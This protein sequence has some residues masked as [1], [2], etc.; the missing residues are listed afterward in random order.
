MLREIK[1]AL[2]LLLIFF[3]FFF[4]SKYYFSEKNIKRNNK[5]ILQYQEKVNTKFDNLPSFKSDTDNIIE[6]T[7]EIKEFNNK[8]ERNF[9]NLLKPNEK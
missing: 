5:I 4:V 2:Y 6:Y 1:Y 7:D 8:K 9:W 3:S